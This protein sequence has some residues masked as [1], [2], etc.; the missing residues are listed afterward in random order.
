MS[1]PFQ[2]KAKI[3]CTDCGEIPPNH[4]TIY[5]TNLRKQNFSHS[6]ILPT[7]NI[8][9]SEV[10]IASHI[11]GGTIILLNGTCGSGKS[12]IAEELVKTHGF[13]AIDGDC[14]MQVVKHKLDVMHVDFDSRELFD[15]ISKEID[16]LLAFGHKIA[17]AHVVMPDDIPKYKA[18]FES[19]G[20]VYRI[21]LLKPS[22]EIAVA[23]TQTRTC[24]GGVTP[25]EWVRYFYDKLTFGNDVEIFD[26]SDM[27]AEQTARSIICPF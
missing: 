8:C 3:I 1:E 16:V 20:L 15:E 26:N 23:R 7:C 11:N 22:Y 9:K 17:L 18:L 5:N 4:V 12:T 24:H 21:I 25:E 14:A 6:P 10:E 19:K 27:S 13:L 2:P